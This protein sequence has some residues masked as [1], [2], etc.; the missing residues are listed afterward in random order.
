MQL[1]TSSRMSVSM[2]RLFSSV[3][4]A[5]GSE[6]VTR[7]KRWAAIGRQFNP[8]ANMTDLSYRT[9]QIF[10]SNL[11]DLEVAFAAGKV[12]LNGILDEVPS[13]SSVH[14][15][16]WSDG[17]ESSSTPRHS[18]IFGT[19]MKEEGKDEAEESEGSL[20]Q[21]V[22]RGEDYTVYKMLVTEGGA[23]EALWYTIFAEYPGLN[24]EDIKIKC[25]SRGIV[26]LTLKNKI[27]QG[28]TPSYLGHGASTS[29]SD[30]EG[31]QCSETVSVIKLPSRIGSA[32]GKAFFTDLG[33]LY[34]RVR[35]GNELTQ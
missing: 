2:L 16:P 32:S 28:G 11:H 17:H 22:G 29:G 33:Q 13:P 10:I 25:F 5:G 15:L 8:P 4:D 14:P 21:V 6:D 23:E 9:K 7:K 31:E 35:K 12:D 19:E 26:R 18:N 20:G 1:R 24:I 30:G 3:L 27:L 34:V